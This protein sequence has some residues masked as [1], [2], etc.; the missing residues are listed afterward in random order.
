MGS[1][2]NVPETDAS[3]PERRA[4]LGHAGAGD[5]DQGV[6]A[7]AEAGRVPPRHG[8]EVAVVNG[9]LHDKGKEEND[10][11]AVADADPVDVAP[12]GVLDHVAEEEGRDEGR[13]DET[14]SPQV[15]LAGL[16]V[17]RRG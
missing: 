8:R 10:D 15:G 17:W 14:H 11:G 12:G 3:R 2:E 7:V 6:E 1:P 13:D 16:Q 9:L 5:T 4:V